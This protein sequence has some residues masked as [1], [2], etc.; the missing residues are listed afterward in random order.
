LNAFVDVTNN[1]GVD[2][3]FRL[4]GLYESGGSAYALPIATVNTADVTVEDEYAEFNVDSNQRQTLVWQL[5]GVYPFA[6]LQASVGTA[7]GTAPIL[8][9]ARLVSAR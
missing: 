6:Q 5:F 3:R 4:Q 7:G 1:T 2:V 9:S 8:N